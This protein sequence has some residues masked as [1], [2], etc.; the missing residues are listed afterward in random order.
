M[1]AVYG[2]IARYGSF[3]SF[4]GFLAVPGFGPCLPDDADIARF[5]E[6]IEDLMHAGV[7]HDGVVVGFRPIDDDVVALGDGAHQGFGMRLPTF[8]LSKET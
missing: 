3:K 7:Q 5:D 8:S 4:A 1:T 6:G 2:A